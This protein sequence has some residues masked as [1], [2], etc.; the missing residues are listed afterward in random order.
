MAH[1]EKFQVAV[2]T[3]VLDIHLFYAGKGTCCVP[4]PSNWSFGPLLSAISVD[5]VLNGNQFLVPRGKNSEGASVGLIVG[6]TLA[7]A[8]LVLL[9]LCCVCGLVVRRR[10]N[11]TTLRLEDQLGM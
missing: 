5:N 10:K 11:R 6:L 3:G 4:Q 1:E 7:S 8:I 2:T 9:V